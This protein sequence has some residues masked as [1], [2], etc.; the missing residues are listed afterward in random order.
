M[1][2]PAVLSFARG[3]AKAKQKCRESVVST[4]WQEVKFIALH[5]PDTYSGQSCSSGLQEINKIAKA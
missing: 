5:H 2:L 1:A 3:L 4:A